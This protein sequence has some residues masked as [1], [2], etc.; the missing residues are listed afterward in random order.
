MI[1]VESFRYYCLN[2]KGVSESFPFNETVLVFK[3]FDKMFVLTDLN[4]DFSISLK[5]EPK[6]VIYLKETHE[7]ISGAYHFNKK[8]WIS[9]KIDGSLH[10]TFIKELIDDSYQLVVSKL[11]KKQRSE[12]EDI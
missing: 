10:D 6:R 9:I 1:D 2:K 12:I 3:V 5:C 11:S 4:K 7:A 8:H